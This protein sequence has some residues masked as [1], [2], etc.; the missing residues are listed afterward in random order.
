[1]RLVVRGYP[2]RLSF[3][4]M[5]LF[6]FGFPDRPATSFSPIFLGE[7]AQVGVTDG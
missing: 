2:D 5:L 1:M 3:D 4:S 7:V 6:L